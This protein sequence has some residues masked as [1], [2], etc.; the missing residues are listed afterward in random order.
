[1]Q[2]H[3]VFINRD[4]FNSHTSAVI[5]PRQ[6]RVVSRFQIIV[7]YYVCLNRVFTTD[8]QRY[9]LRIQYFL[10]FVFV[11][12]L[13]CVRSSASTVFLCATINR[14]LRKIRY[15][16]RNISTTTT[17]NFL[18][19]EKF[20]S[21]F[22]ICSGSRYI[23]LIL[24]FI[25]PDFNWKSGFGR[26]SHVDIDRRFFFYFID[27]ELLATASV[28]TI[29]VKWVRSIVK[30]FLPQKPHRIKMVIIHSTMIHGSK[31]FFSTRVIS[32]KRLDCIKK[33]ISL[34]SKK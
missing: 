33:N 15:H 19:S 10:P 32:D 28:H 5:V 2:C 22:S 4:I 29:Y 26:F 13:P 17:T 6:C 27:N 8:I 11:R 34:S 20:N 16:I 12:R 21:H 24:L 23:K 31:P 3:F 1:M 25:S 7:V 14:H 9:I 18:C 30:R